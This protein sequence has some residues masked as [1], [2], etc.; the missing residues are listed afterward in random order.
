MHGFTQGRDL[1]EETEACHVVIM[2]VAMA[3]IIPVWD[4]ISSFSVKQI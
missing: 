2:E 3:F 4:I 1:V